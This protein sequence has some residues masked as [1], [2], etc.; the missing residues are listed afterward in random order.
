MGS[1]YTK[2]PF[3]IKKI[4][5][6]GAGPCGLSAAKYLLAQGFTS[7]AIFEQQDEVGGIWYYSNEPTN[8]RLVPQTNP[9]C[10]PD[11]P[12]HTGEGEAPMFPT[13]MYK[14]LHANIVGT[15]MNFVDLKFPS[16]SWV[17]PS[18]E[19]IQAYVVKYAEQVRPLIRFCYQVKSVRLL[20]L[21][22]RSLALEK[23]EVEAESTVS[24]DTV[25][26][27]YD[28]VVVANGHYSTPFLPDIP[29]IKEF[30]EAHPEVIIHSKHYRSPTSYTGQ[31]VIVI[32]NG[33]SGLDIAYQIGKSCRKP[34]LLSV[35]H[36]TRPDKLEHTGADEIPEIKEFLPDV[37][38]V[39]LVDG[40]IEEHIDGI[41]FCTGFLFSYPFL[42]DLAGKLLTV[43]K[44]VHSL[45]QHLFYIR[46]PT[47]VFPGLNMRAVPFPVSETQAAVFAAVWA[48][49][50]E[51]PPVEEMENWADDLYR[52]QGEALHVFPQ[53]GDG[54]YLNAMH[55]WAL[56]ASPRGKEP[57]YWNDELL[58]Q[59]SIYA[60]AKLRFEQQ[61]G[62]AK[63][64]A[65]LGFIYPG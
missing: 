60:E 54:V 36:P 15:L 52:R 27:I 12:I 16:E 44:G 33:P 58:W 48:N 65:E 7:I 22:G 2:T 61:G 30:H 34:L 6:I 64:L 43:G 1:S 25:K 45:Y 53:A 24:G 47:L 31:K 13:P 20:P 19:D 59:R 51:L 50:L 39:R 63:T 57:A 38:G 29:G 4:A 18:R 3:D 55:D 8:A 5:I 14:T 42:P 26:E 32:G 62:T 21:E 49:A 56:K 46:H 35:R 9:F 40:H 10:P 28:A 11:P 17:F 23:W 41:V 37:R